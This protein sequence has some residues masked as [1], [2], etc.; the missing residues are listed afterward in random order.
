MALQVDYFPPIIVPAKNPVVFHISAD[1]G[2]P[3]KENHKIGLQVFKTG[4]DGDEQIFEDLVSVY[5]ANNRAIAVFEIS[6]LLLPSLKSYFQLYTQA[7]WNAKIDRTEMILPFYVK[8]YEQFGSPASP[9]TLKTSNWFYALNGG[10][11]S[12]KRSSFYSVYDNFC[13]YVISQKKQFLTWRNNAKVTDI[14]ATEKLYFLVP[15]DPAKINYI[16]KVTRHYFDDGDEEENIDIGHS[17]LVGK[18]YELD[19]SYKSVIESYLGNFS[20]YS[21]QVLSADELYFGEI[22]EFRMDF[23]SYP[24]ARYFVFL[25]SLGAFEGIRFTGEGIKD[26][27]LSRQFYDK[28]SLQLYSSSTASR[29]QTNPIVTLGF[30]V[31]TGW[32]TNQELE[33]LQDFLISPEIFEIKDGI[34]I[35]AMIKND[36]FE[37]QKD[38][39][40]LNSLTIEMEYLDFSNVYQRDTDNAWQD[41]EA[42]EPPYNEA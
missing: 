36:K 34:R 35:P 30:K 18:V 13:K 10:V 3:L 14:N 9:S 17:M 33:Y 5:Y 37:L 32:I 39:N 27:A 12:W 8:Y 28:G 20:G 25:N 16:L 42:V 40:F 26:I 23:R 21:V 11:P 22:F 4:A 7:G 1:P 6:E 29:G 41:V 24:N 38:N 15:E 19:V 31:N 2:D